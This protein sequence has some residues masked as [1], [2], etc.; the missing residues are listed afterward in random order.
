MH[1]LIDVPS[2]GA[3]QKKSRTND[4]R[5]AHV[6]T[7][8]A[9]KNAHHGKTEAGKTEAGKTEAGKTEAG[10]TEAGKTEAGKTDFGLERAIRPAEEARCHRTKEGVQHE[11]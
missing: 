3:P 9:G 2:S 8:P 1:D 10:K 5:Q 11:I 6:E 7:A 4:G